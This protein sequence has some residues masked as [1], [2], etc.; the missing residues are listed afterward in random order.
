MFTDKHESSSMWIWISYMYN[1]D[2]R[3]DID[4]SIKRV[5]YPQKSIYGLQLFMADQKYHLN[6]L[7]IISGVI[8]T[9]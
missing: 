9:S 2:V 8:L 6:I 3:Y 4:R 1:N 5:V 7:N